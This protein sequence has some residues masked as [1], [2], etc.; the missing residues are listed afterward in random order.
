MK[1]AVACSGP[2]GPDKLGNG[3]FAE[4]AT[5]DAVR[6]CS[7]ICGVENNWVESKSGIFRYTGM[8]SILYVVV[9][10]GSFGMKTGAAT[11]NSG[12]SFNSDSGGGVVVPG[13]VLPP[14][15]SWGRGSVQPGLE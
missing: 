6:R 2:S 4:D 12:S 8:V 10:V 13:S 9:D 1:T 7:S 3:C 11:F 14:P 5:M 15:D